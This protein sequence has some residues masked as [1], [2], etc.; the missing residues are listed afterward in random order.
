MQIAIDGPSGA[1]KST[2][3]K[4]LSKELDFDY[5][6]TGAM[7]RG[8]ALGLKKL[9]IEEYNDNSL[10]NESLSKIKLDVKDNKIFLNDKDVSEEIR[11]EE[12]GMLASK[13]SAYPIVREYLVKLQRKIAEGKDII[14]DGRDVGT[15]ILKN[16]DYKIF[17]T[18]SLEERTNRRYN[19][20]LEKGMKPNKEEI[21][22]DL[23]LRDYNDTHR[24]HSPLKM[25]ED[26]IELDCTDLSVE[27]TIKEIMNI[28]NLKDNK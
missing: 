10:L 21:K 26:G 18:A 20:L 2:I 13:V 24:K 9:G 16:A 8:L 25:A 15:V 23:K 14:M 4:Y 12:I 11:N 6:D 7:Y 17:L 28:I 19:Q 5:L 22:K 27:E 3:A 1:G